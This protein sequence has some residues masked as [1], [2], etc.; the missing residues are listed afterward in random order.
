MCIVARLSGTE[1]DDEDY[2]ELEAVLHSQKK[3]RHVGVVCSRRGL[4][5]N[6][7]V[8]WVGLVISS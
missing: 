6:P 1:E 7:L 3:V 5:Y 8:P 2:E 4:F